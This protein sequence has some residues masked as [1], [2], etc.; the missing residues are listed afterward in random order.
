MGKSVN[1]KSRLQHL[2]AEAAVVVLGVRVTACVTFPYTTRW[3]LIQ[4]FGL[5]I[6]GHTCNTHASILSY[7]PATFAVGTETVWIRWSLY[8]K[9][10]LIS[11]TCK[12][13]NLYKNTSELLFFK[14]KL[15]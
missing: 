4:T 7:C 6:S 8:A 2:C 10:R 13:V 14:N 1:Q 11:L 3:D 15:L 9:T 5:F 12:S